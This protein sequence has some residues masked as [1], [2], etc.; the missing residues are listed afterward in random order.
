MCKI[1]CLFV[2]MTYISLQMLVCL[3][4][5]GYSI[6]SFHSFVT[7]FTSNFDILKIQDI[8][9]FFLAPVEDWWMT[10][11]GGNILQIYWILIWTPVELQKCCFW[12]GIGRHRVSKCSIPHNYIWLGIAMIMQNILYSGIVQYT[13][14][15]LQWRS[16][17]IPV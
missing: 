7:S 9:C 13:G 6:S 16:H 11:L 1:I 5:I 12:F 14:I 8:A 15:L 17:I 10:F 2:Y 4:V 3:V